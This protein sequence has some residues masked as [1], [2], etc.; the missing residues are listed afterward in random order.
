V[1]PLIHRLR[2][3]KIESNVWIGDDVYIDGAHP[4]A[5]EI[6]EGA[7]IA[8]RSTIIGHTMGTGR[9]VIGKRAAVC[10]G[11]TIVC[12]SGKTLTIGEGAVVSAGST[13]SNDIPAHTLC[14]P[15]RIQIYGTVE[16]PL[17]GAATLEEFRRGLKPL[18]RHQEVLTPNRERL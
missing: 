7:A 13:V 2:G 8:M 3:V 1:R 5:V 14:G 15:P 6:R 11:C 9:V 17:R 16:T 12:S 10:A 18:R 4:E